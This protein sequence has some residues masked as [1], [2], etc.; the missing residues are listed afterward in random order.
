MIC[1]AATAPEELAG[2]QVGY[3]GEEEKAKDEQDQKSCRAGDLTLSS[4]Q[5]LLTPRHVVGL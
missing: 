4:V 2:E 5:A 1:R 3:R